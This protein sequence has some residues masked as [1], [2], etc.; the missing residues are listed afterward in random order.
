MFK[1]RD[2]C[3]ETFVRD[4]E[5]RRYDAVAIFH[6]PSTETYRYSPQQR[7]ESGEELYAVLEKQDHNSNAW[8]FREKSLAAREYLENN[9][10][11]GTMMIGYQA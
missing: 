1:T 10:L 5:M 4:S 8:L 2:E 3:M 11:P 6:R 9:P 7:R